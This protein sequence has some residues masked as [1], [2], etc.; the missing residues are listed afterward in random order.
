MESKEVCKNIS[1]FPSFSLDHKYNTS[2]CLQ[3]LHFRYW[4]EHLHVIFYL[5]L[6]Q[7]PTDDVIILFVLERNLRFSEVICPWLCGK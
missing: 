5:I 3:V 2:E 1:E 4:A 6:T 7:Q